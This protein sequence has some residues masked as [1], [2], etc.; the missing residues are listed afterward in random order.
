[1]DFCGGHVAETGV[2]RRAG[3]RRRRV[4]KLNTE[5]RE[6][7]QQHGLHEKKILSLLFS[8]LDFFFI[9]REK[10]REFTWPGKARSDD[11]HQPQDSEEKLVKQ[12]GSLRRSLRRA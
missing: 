3:G 2:N 9:K 4:A 6:S 12:K 8:H 7:M 5:P 10:E 1:M 11:S